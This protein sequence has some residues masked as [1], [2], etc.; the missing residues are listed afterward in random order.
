MS[1]NVIKAGDIRWPQCGFREAP[2]QDKE[3]DNDRDIEQIQ[4]GHL[5][6]D[7]FCGSTSTERT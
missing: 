1:V 4:H 5:E 6:L 2:E 3:C 7:G